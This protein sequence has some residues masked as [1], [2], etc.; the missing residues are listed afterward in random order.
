MS[1]ISNQAVKGRTNGCSATCLGR[2]SPSTLTNSLKKK[3]A[4]I[5]LHYLPSIEFFATLLAYPVIIIE[6]HENYQ[7]GSYRNRCHLVNANGPQVLSIPLQKG[8]HQKLPIREV[9][10]A[11]REPWHIQ[12]WRSIK[13]AYANA[14]F[15]PYFSE[16]IE[17]LFQQR[18]DYLF[19]FN[20]KLFELLIRLSGLEL[21]YQYSTTYDPEPGED[22]ADLRGAISPRNK[23]R[24]GGNRFTPVPYPQVFTERHGFLP[25]LSIL[26]LL[27][28]SG[29]ETRD[30]LQRSHP[31]AE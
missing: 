30:I 27:F 15:F 16:P 24:T 17:Q 20:R 12:H 2:S 18:P 19:D 10:I 11:Y 4:L 21:T 1:I 3:Y 6:Q 31:P 26:D 7:K 23:Q 22:T 5:E 25:N 29:P 14:P 9:K 28:C 13:S 8:K